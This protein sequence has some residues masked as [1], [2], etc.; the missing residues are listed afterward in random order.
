MV[1][2][3]VILVLLNV[4]QVTD[5]CGKLEAIKREK[6]ILAYHHEG[7]T[8]IYDYYADGLLITFVSMSGTSLHM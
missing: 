1:H 6:H 4:E 8:T 2:N 5:M 3:L 7:L